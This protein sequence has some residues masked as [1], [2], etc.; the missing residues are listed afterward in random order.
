MG[1]TTTELLIMEW[2]TLASFGAVLVATIACIIWII[3][4]GMDS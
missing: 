2:R 4:G 3:D 1:M